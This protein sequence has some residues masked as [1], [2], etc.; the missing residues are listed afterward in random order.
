MKP[1]SKG[2]NKKDE[3]YKNGYGNYDFSKRPV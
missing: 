2:S 1:T 3:H